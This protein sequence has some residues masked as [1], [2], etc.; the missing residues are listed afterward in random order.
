MCVGNVGSWCIVDGG[1]L[2][3]D[4][5]DCERSRLLSLWCFCA[6]SSVSLDFVGDRL[7]PR[8][9]SGSSGASVL[10][11]A[12]LVLCDDTTG[13]T[14]GVLGVESPRLVDLD[15]F[16][17]TGVCFCLC[18][19]LGGAGGG[20]GGAL[21]DGNGDGYLEDLDLS[22]G[23]AILVIVDLSSSGRGCGMSSSS[24]SNGIGCA[25]A[26]CGSCLGSPRS[27]PK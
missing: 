19:G 7:L 13:D 12:L 23:V 27:P 9:V 16:V 5:C 2:L 18:G 3:D 11:V 21:S 8:G 1:A 10:A 14:C 22:V 4:A 15:L 20:A 17:C 26:S 24:T 25:G 6:G